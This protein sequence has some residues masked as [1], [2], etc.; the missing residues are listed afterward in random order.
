[1]HSSQR[2]W[3][4]KEISGRHLPCSGSRCNSSDDFA[5]NMFRD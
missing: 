1:L 4:L 2:K 5:F 3:V